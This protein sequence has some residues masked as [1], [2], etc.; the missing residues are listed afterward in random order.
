MKNPNQPTLMEDGNDRKKIKVSLPGGRYQLSL[1]DPGVVLLED[2][3]GY[4][5]GDV[6]SDLLVRILVACGDAWFPNQ[7][8][9]RSIVA[10]IE[11]TNDPSAHELQALA[12]FLR[13]RN[14]PEARAKVVRNLVTTSP[15]SNHL[16]PDEIAVNKLPT[17]PP[18]IF[19]ESA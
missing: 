3:L 5:S 1:N 8:N 10:D 4:T 19:D 9:Y 2:E 7:S 6:V 12:D 14:V 11:D 15:L 18:G 13:S 17:A 16:Q